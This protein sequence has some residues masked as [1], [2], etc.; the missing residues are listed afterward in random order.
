MSF[1]VTLNYVHH[2]PVHHGYGKELGLYG[3]KG[4]VNLKP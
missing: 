2:N 3:E 1:W 4:I